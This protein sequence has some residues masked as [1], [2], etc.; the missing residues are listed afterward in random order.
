MNSFCRLRTAELYGAGKTPEYKSTAIENLGDPQLQIPGTE[1]KGQQ[2][3]KNE[4]GGDWVN[5]L[6]Y[7][8]NLLVMEALLTG[9]EA[10]GLPSMRGKIDLI[11][12]DPP[13]DSKA[14]Y[15]TKITLPNGDINQKPTVI[16]QFAYADTWKD[17]T[18]SYLKMMYPR[19]ALM[20][21][22]LSDKGSIYVHID[23][24]VGHYVKI[25]LD[26]IFGRQNFRNE[27]IWK[28][29]GPISTTDN[30]PK[31]HDNIY[32]YTKSNKWFF[33]H[34]ACLIEYDEKAIKRYDKID[35]DGNKYKLYNEEDGK[36]RKAYLKEGKPTEVFHIPFVQGTSNERINYSTQK[37]EALLERLIQASS[38]KDN[39]VLDCYAGSGTTAAVAEKL[40]RRW[41]MSDLGKPACMIMR[42]RLIDQES[43]PFLYQSIGDYQKEQFEKS[44]FKSIG[45]LAH[46]VMNLYGAM[47]FPMQQGT[48]LNL[49]MIKQ[50]QTLVFVDSPNKLTGIWTLKRA[51]MPRNTYMGGWNKVIVLGWNFATD[52]GQAISSLNDDKLEVLVIPPDLLDRL[53]T[54]S[55]YDKL[56]KTGQIRFSS[57]QYLS[58]K[59]III[60]EGKES[61]EI[62][63]ELDNY[64]L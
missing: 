44:E 5:R 1:G 21:E 58:I 27:I 43:K 36:V 10:S 8:D 23:W 31:K 60:T 38:D 55:S 52:I 41:I 9:D 59:P 33:N 20:R 24:H 63:V 49:G 45:D 7:G 13:F 16:E 39:L 56:I 18:V 46:V 4:I 22:L 3:L 25:L 15:R 40:G 61:D 50:S 19:L 11:Y 54:K 30:Y 6:V 2:K 32:F 29:F 53:K 12:I 35:E 26:E 64:I 42:K 57:L 34:S 28:Y 37:P 48:P 62:K 47:P 14:D 51:Q 17:G